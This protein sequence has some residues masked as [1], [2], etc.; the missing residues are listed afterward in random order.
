MTPPGLRTAYGLPRPQQSQPTKPPSAPNT[1]DSEVSD[2]EQQDSAITKVLSSRLRHQALVCLASLFAV[3][4][5]SLLLS[6]TLVP[7]LLQA[8]GPRNTFSYWLSFLPDTPR[9]PHT[10]PSLLSCALRDPNHKAREV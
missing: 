5:S 1:S 4:S 2:S 8:I 6:V 10:P 3:S 9:L 7:C